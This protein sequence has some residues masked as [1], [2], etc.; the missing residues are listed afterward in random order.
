MFQQVTGKF[1]IILG[2]PPQFPFNDPSTRLDKNGGE[3]G[4][5]FMNILLSNY[6]R[7][8][9]HSSSFLLILYSYIGNP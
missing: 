2:N 8:L 4:Y 5:K 3:E 9:K 7:Y 1:D 6:S